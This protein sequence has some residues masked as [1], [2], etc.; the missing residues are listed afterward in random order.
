MDTLTNIDNFDVKKLQF[1]EPRR[2]GKD[3]GKMIFVTLGKASLMIQTP[4]MKMPFGISKFQ[5]DKMPTYSLSMSFEG[6]A[7]DKQKKNFYNK[8]IEFENK[9]KI[10]LKNNCVAW[11][12]KK[13]ITDEYINEHFSSIIKISKDPKYKPRL[14]FKINYSNNELGL[15][16]F[17]DELNEIKNVNENAFEKN[18]EGIALIK[19]SGIWVSSKGF[20]CSWKVQQLKLEKGGAKNV[21]E[22]YPTASVFLE[23]DE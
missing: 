10:E 1:S 6:M 7:I 23:D 17:D 8:I 9:V 21:T 14:N 22:N 13:D 20:G 5:Y 12:K 4:V 2:F 3:E 18:R 15:T 19:C 16:L 11:L